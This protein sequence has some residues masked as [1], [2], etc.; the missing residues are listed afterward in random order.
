MWLYVYC[1]LYL[2]GLIYNFIPKRRKKKIFYGEKKISTN[3]KINFLLE[4]INLETFAGPVALP[5]ILTPKQKALAVLLATCRRLFETLSPKRHEKALRTDT[6]SQRSQPPQFYLEHVCFG[7]LFLSDRFAPN[8]SQTITK[9]K[10]VKKR[11]LQGVQKRKPIKRRRKNLMKKV[12]DYLG[13]D[14]YMFAPLISSRSK[15]FRS[16]PAS[17]F[18]FSFFN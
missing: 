18:L 6:C 2:H 13:W 14:S 10:M 16:S 7:K 15:I 12:A 9:K 17:N 5:Y 8:R 3:C 4:E 1:S 11:P